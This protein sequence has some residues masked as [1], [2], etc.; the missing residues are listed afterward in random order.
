[1]TQVE[2]TQAF[3]LAPDAN[4]Q[5]YVVREWAARDPK[6]AA[7][8]IETVPVEHP[9]L[10]AMMADVVRQYAHYDI[11]APAKWLNQFPPSPQTDRAVEIYARSSMARDAPGAMTWATSIT[12]PVIRARAVEQVAGEWRN[13]DPQSLESFLQEDTNLTQQQ[14]HQL[15][16]ESFPAP[17]PTSGE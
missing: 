1:M 3:H 9:G 6:A 7:A 2:P 15:L 10:G 8:F 12:D 17:G 13:Q 14:K 5:R 11:D 4:S 16:P